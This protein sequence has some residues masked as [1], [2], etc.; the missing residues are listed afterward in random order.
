VCVVEIS[1][2]TKLAPARVLLHPFLPTA[3]AGGRL[4]SG[5]KQSSG[6]ASLIRLLGRDEMPRDGAITFVTGMA[7]TSMMIDQAPK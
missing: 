2:I 1:V 7:C 3:L 4:L 6:I 5:A